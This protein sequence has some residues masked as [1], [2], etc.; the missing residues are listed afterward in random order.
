MKQKT[1]KIL[2]I[3]KENYGHLG[4]ELKFR[5]SFEVLIAT[6]LSAQCTDK[7]V[8]KVTQPLFE[9]H[10]SPEKILALGEEGLYEKIKTCGLAKTKA[11][12][13]ILTCEKLIYEFDNEIPNEI[14]KLTEL[15]GVGRKTASIVLAFSMGIPAI[16]VD[17]HVFRTANRL[18]IVKA[19][20]ALA[21]E[22]QLRK[23]L[24]EKL[25]IPS[26]HWFIW[27]GRMT[28]KS[29]NPR[30]AECKL[31]ELCEFSEKIK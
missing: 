24:P 9:T 8:N 26:H 17:T 10:D 14:E 12:N 22:M 13:I 20:T 19:K 4:S 2:E 11:K 6:I 28:C 21:T 15:A 5:N 23:I 16:P 31:F 1:K 7:Q 18:G 30:C 29:Q 25:W 27:L 3:L